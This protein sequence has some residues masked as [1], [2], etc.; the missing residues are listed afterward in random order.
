MTYYIRRDAIGQWRWRL[1]AANHRIVAE[2]G[3]A[4]RNRDDCI[5]AIALV[6]GST[7]SPIREE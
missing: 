7:T 2:S 5:A 3:E 6:K 1:R 4:Y